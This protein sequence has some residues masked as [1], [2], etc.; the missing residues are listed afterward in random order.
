VKGGIEVE[1]NKSG[2]GKEY[3]ESLKLLNERIRELQSIRI[4][5]IHSYAK[6]KRIAEES[7]ELQELK[8]RLAPLILMQKDLREATI[9]VEEYYTPEHY[10]NSKITM[11][12]REPHVEK[13]APLYYDM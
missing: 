7:G 9:E 1:L 10:R 3:R 8:A 12:K 4:E 5:L 6:I 2:L 11:N 13:Y